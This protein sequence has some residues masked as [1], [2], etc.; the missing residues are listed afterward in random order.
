MKINIGGFSIKTSSHLWGARC[1]FVSILL[2]LC[3]IGSASAFTTLDRAACWSAYTNAFYYTD[4]SGRGYFRGME[5]G[6]AVQFNLWQDCERLEMVEDAVAVGLAGTNM[7]NA[8][9]A[10]ITNLEGTAWRSWDPFN[11]D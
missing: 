5:G 7:V 8:L 2:L 3:G 6:T 11:D 1:L 4:S 10:G 9:C